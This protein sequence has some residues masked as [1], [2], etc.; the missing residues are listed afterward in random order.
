MTYEMK[1]GSFSLFKNDKKLTEKHP[2]YKGSI[3][4][5]GVEHW[6]DGWL[7]EGKKGKF[8]SG[9]I[10]DPKQK[11]FTPKGDDEMP[12]KDDDF[13]FQGKTMKKIITGVV[14]YM[15]LMSSAYACQTTTIIVNGKVTICTVCGTVV[16]CM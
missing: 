3:K 13:A 10:G 5:N 11:G 1:D 9:R 6:F 4:I 14:T 15:L 12:V 2:D 16:S 7:K 8:L